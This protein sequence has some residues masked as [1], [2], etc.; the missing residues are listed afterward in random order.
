MNLDNQL[1]LQ[2]CPH[3]NVDTPSLLE[4]S[5]FQTLANNGKGRRH[6]KTYR[7][8]RCGGV[9]TASSL[10]NGGRVE[11]IYP[12]PKV[13]EESVPP[14]A[15]NYLEQAI[16]SLSSPA[17]AT[18]L[19]ASSVDAMLKDKDYISGSLYERINKA[20]KDNLITE[21][22]AKWAH[23]VRLDANEQRH[24]DADANLP[25]ADDA[26]KTVDFALA[27]AEFL[28]VLPSKVAQGIV[29]SRPSQ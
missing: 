24:A 20:V 19:A 8:S 14:K 12:E 27:L 21:D 17:G 13:V 23:Q 25:S 18:M 9:V 16:N 26:A 29:N 10:A 11:K 2:R 1:T 5:A 7:C 4:T 28:F 6:W 3:C 22:M 15:K